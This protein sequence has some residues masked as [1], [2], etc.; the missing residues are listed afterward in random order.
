MLDSTVCDIYL[1]NENG[2][3]AGR[4]ILTAA[5]DA[6]TSLCLGYSL[7]WENDTK[8]LQNL[9]VNI[10]EDKVLF[11]EKKGIHMLILYHK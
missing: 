3:L 11:C 7:T 2:E 5:C 1:L 4:P 9:M 6:N 8:S 10:L